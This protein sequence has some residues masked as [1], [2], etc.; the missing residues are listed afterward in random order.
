MLFLLL[1][2][3]DRFGDLLAF[4]VEQISKPLRLLQAFLSGK[5]KTSV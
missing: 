1:I 3:L 2:S 4:D 5:N